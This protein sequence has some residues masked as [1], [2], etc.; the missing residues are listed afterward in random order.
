[1]AN[2]VTFCERV[3]NSEK[4][5][6]VIGEY[7][8]EMNGLDRNVREVL[9]RQFFKLRKAA[10]YSISLDLP[11]KQD[12]FELNVTSEEISTSGNTI[13]LSDPK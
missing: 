6:P 12:N 9:S 13:E 10:D 7:S 4:L 8:M 2:E 5:P 11:E 3:F 1:M